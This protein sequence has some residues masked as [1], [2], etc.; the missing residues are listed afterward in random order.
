MFFRVRIAQLPVYVLF[1]TNAM[2][3]VE[4]FQFNFGMSQ[5][6]LLF[7]IGHLKN[8]RIWPAIQK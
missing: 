6:Q 4:E 7:I 1:S 8:E 5:V 2:L 3:T